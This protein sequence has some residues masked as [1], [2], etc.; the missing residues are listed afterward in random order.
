[1]QLNEKNGIQSQVYDYSVPE[2]PILK[3]LFFETLILKIRTF[4]TIF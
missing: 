2:V 1:M 3:I 4:P